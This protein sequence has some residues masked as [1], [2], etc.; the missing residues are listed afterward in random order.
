MNKLARASY[1]LIYLFTALSSLQCARAQTNSDSLAHASKGGTIDSTIVEAQNGDLF[2]Y[3]RPKP[4]SFITQVPRTLAM[5]TKV[6]FQRKSIPALSAMAGLTV[7]L[8]GIDQQITDGAQQFGRSVDLDGARKYGSSIGFKI[9]SKQVDIFEVPQN[10]NSS[11]YTLGEGLTSIVLSGALLT[12]GKIKKNYRMIQTAN[13]ILQTQ[14]SVGVI[15]QTFKRISGRES[16]FRAT[17]P[18]GVWRPL[19]GFST[20]LNNTSHYDAFPSGHLATVMAT[21]TVLAMNYPEKKWIYWMGGS[22]ISLI[23][24]SMIN[25]GVHWVSDYPLAIGIGYVTARATVKLNRVI[26]FKK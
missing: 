21:F 6:T 2:I 7:V 4:F 17:A 11:I 18:G 12:C 3:K 10:L 1:A 9:G 14:L 13:Q 16:P 5:S 26:Q 23:G 8:I 22:L 25:N 20:Y 24:F 19:P 15:T